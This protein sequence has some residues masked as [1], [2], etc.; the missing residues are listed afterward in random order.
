MLLRYVDDLLRMLIKKLAEEKVVSA[1]SGIVPTKTISQILG[2]RQGGGMIQ[3]IG[4]IIERFPDDDCLYLSVSPKYVDSTFKE[5][6]I[7][8][9]PKSVPD[10]SIHLAKTDEVSKK[11][12]SPE[13]YSRFR[14]ALGRLLWLPQVKELMLQHGSRCWELSNLPPLKGLRQLFVRC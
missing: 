9:G 7:T 3:F 12:L 5:L 13:S 6:Q 4:H 8:K 10:V 11:P 2:A 14:R 1:I